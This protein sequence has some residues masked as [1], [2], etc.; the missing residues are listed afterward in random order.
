MVNGPGTDI[1]VDSPIIALG[2]VRESD[3]RLELH[4]GRS[5]R[6]VDI[7]LRRRRL[8]LGRR[9]QEDSRRWESTRSKWFL[10][11]RTKTM[12]IDDDDDDDFVVHAY[13]FVYA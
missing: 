10:E 6:V 5:V 4:L 13:Y 2:G 1:K 8:R 11:V 3:R 12:G 7:I 9:P